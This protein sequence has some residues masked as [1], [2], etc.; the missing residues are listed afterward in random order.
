LSGS[1][2]AMLPRLS[3]LAFLVAI[4]AL[5]SASTLIY[6][7]THPELDQNL[8]RAAH[9]IQS[10]SAHLTPKTVFEAQEIPFLWKR[11][12]KEV[13]KNVAHVVSSPITSFKNNNAWNRAYVQLE[14]T[15]RDV[16]RFNGEANAAEKSRAQAEADLTDS[17]PWVADGA[18]IRL[19]VHPAVQGMWTNRLKA[20][21][22]QRTQALG[23][24]QELK[25]SGTLSPSL[26]P[27]VEE[28]LNAPH[29]VPAGEKFDYDAYLE[30][31]AA[32]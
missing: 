18:R 3:L 20:A 21:E 7:R 16:T 22:G 17:R 4:P 8:P 30:D 12:L 15:N 6:T 31:A 14:N 26:T 25:D 28:L 19:A 11:G 5:A 1:S 32:A 10:S 2:E 13:A 29:P 9:R 24:L 27:K 23:K